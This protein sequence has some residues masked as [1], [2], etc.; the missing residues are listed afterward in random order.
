MGSLFRAQP[1]HETIS[2]VRS[3][4]RANLAAVVS[5]SRRKEDSAPVI[6]MVL[7]I[8]QSVFV[9]IHTPSRKGWASQ[10]LHSPSSDLGSARE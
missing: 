7:R 3:A 4:A 2:A 8:Q 9:A 5:Q 1:L 6:F 10:A